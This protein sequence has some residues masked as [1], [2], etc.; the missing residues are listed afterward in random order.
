LIECFIDLRLV[1]RR[2][3]D[4]FEI[5]PDTQQEKGDRALFLPFNGVLFNRSERRDD[6]LSGPAIEPMTL[7]Q[8]CLKSARPIAP[9]PLPAVPFPSHK[10]LLRASLLTDN[11]PE[12]RFYPFNQLAIGNPFSDLSW[13]K[14][15]ANL[16]HLVFGDRNRE[17]QAFEGGTA[18]ENMKMKPEL[19]MGH[20]DVKPLNVGIERFQRDEQLI[21]WR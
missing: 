6:L 1:L 2:D 7:D 11:L 5:A 18:P 21:E 10:H 13:F 3:L 19:A 4:S 14:G 16:S 17:F 12:L 20:R 9:F 15:G 8:Y